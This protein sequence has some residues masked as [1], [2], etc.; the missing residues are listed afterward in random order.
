MFG[1]IATQ[2]TNHRVGCSPISS[3]RHHRQLKLQV[4]KFQLTLRRM[5]D[6][7]A[8]LEKAHNQA[9]RPAVPAVAAQLEVFGLADHTHPAAPE[10]GDD[11]I[12]RDGLA[13]HG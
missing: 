1:S 11:A 5:V 7:W 13:N 2:H 10:L 4:K 8:N 9:A 12:V 6:L 3:N